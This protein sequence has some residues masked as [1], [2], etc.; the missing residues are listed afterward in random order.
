VRTET[1]TVGLQSEVDDCV[2]I[3]MAQ[4]GRRLVTPSSAARASWEGSTTPSLT[5][6]L[7]IT[8][9]LVRTLWFVFLVHCSVS[10]R[11]SSVSGSVVSCKNKDWRLLTRSSV[12]LNYVAPRHFA[13][14]LLVLN[15]T[16]LKSRFAEQILSMLVSDFPINTTCSTLKDYVVRSLTNALFI[17]LV[18]SFKFT[19]KY[20]IISLLHV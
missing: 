1:L 4:P 12:Y 6:Q 5:D 16:G 14:W 7:V 18:K 13:G 20:T 8:L 9:I 2:G 15:R 10:A 3:L 19:L 11:S 17:N